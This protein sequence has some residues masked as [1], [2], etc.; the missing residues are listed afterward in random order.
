MEDYLHVPSPTSTETNGIPTYA[1]ACA[2][3]TD[4]ASA[5][6][7]AAITA[8]TVVAPTPTVYVYD[9][10]PLC[11]N[12]ATCAQGYSNA[13]CGNGAGICIPTGSEGGVG[14][15]I[16]AG[17]CG[18]PCTKNSGCLTG[19]CLTD[20]CCGSTCVNPSVQFVTQWAP[21][22]A[23]LAKK[24]FGDHFGHFGGGF[25]KIAHKLNIVK[26]KVGLLGGSKNK[27]LGPYLPENPQ[28]KGLKFDKGK[29]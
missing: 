2:A 4:Y 8:S 13:A 27:I 10:L 7:C 1:S 9:K 19:L 14:Y 12:P 11:G 5:C 29:E 17:N 16:A 3:S 23:K 20:V 24:S 6:A 26:G 28:P 25:N 22:H 21:P 15:C 18:P